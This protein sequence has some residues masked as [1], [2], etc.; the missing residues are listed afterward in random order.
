VKQSKKSDFVEVTMGQRVMRTETAP[1][2][3]LAILQ[4]RF[5]DI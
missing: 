2:A 1:I 3:A 5:G 4:Y